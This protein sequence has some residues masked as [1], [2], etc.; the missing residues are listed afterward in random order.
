MC[1]M[2]IGIISDWYFLGQLPRPAEGRVPRTWFL[3][4]CILA[5]DVKIK[6]VLEQNNGVPSEHFKVV[7]RKELKEVAFPGREPRIVKKS[8][9]GYWTASVNC[10]TFAKAFFS[11]LQ[12]N[13]PDRDW[14]WPQNLPPYE[15]IIF[16]VRFFRS[17]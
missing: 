10:Y 14:N 13:H 6:L 15:P 17:K 9:Q 12:T 7:D 11:R 8:T 16:N 4:L 3:H 1:C 5:C 2:P